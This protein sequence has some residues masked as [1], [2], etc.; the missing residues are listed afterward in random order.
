[1]D[2][3]EEGLHR[4]WSASGRKQPDSDSSGYGTFGL[5]EIQPDKLDCVDKVG[6]SKYMY[7]Y[8]VRSCDHLR[9]MQQIIDVTC[10]C[11]AHGARGQLVHVHVYSVRVWVIVG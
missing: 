4:G 6:K 11:S 5:V 9:Y 1:M 8:S 2:P 7:M 3:K 10:N